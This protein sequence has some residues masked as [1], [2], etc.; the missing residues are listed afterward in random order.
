MENNAQ[1]AAKSVCVACGEE[2]TSD[3]SVCPKDGTPLTKLQTSGLI[4]SVLGDRYE[5][6]SLIGD[7][8]MG[9]VY[10]ARHKLLKRIVAVKMLHQNL[11]AGASALK[12]FQKEAELA[13]ALNHPNILT[14]HD[15]GVTDEGSPYLVMA[16]LEGKSLAEATAGGK[17]LELK[18]AIHIFKQVCQ[19][20]GHAHEHGVVHRD[21]KPSNIMLVKLDDD[22][23]FVK[24]VDF[25]IA[26]LLAPGES[27]DNLTRTGEVFGSPPYMSPEQCR[28]K[29]VDARS[30]IYAMGCLMYRTVSG[31]QPISGNDLIEYLYKHVNETP[32][33]FSIVAPEL[34]IPA[35]LEEVIFKA[36][37]KA[38]EDRFQSMAELKAALEPI[39]N[40]IPGA[41]LTSTEI[42][43]LVL[44]GELEKANAEQH[45]A[46]ETE[47][48]K[49][50]PESSAAEKADK[51]ETVS[52]AIADT[53]DGAIS[54]SIKLSASVPHEK[55]R[56]ADSATVGDVANNETQ[57]KN[58]PLSIT[59]AASPL[60]QGLKQKL[61]IGA[62]AVILLGTIASALIFKGD[63]KPVEKE[64]SKLQAEAR[65]DYNKGNYA[66]A[67][68]KIREAIKLADKA[69]SPKNAINHHL[70]GLMQYAMGSFDDAQ[71]N[72]EQA[73]S[74]YQ[75]DYP[76]DIAAISDCEAYLGRAATALGQYKEAEDMLKKSLS[77]RQKKFGN[78]DLNVAD[79]LTGL[80]YLN[81]RRKMIAPAEEELT[82]ALA[83]TEKHTGAASQQTAAALNNLGQAQQLAGKYKE[84]ENLYRKGL[85]I[86]S[87][88]LEK[89]SPYLADSYNC[90]G[91]VC[92]ATGR[93]KEARD[94][95]RKAL[96]IQE[97]TLSPSDPR[98]TQTQKQYADVVLK[99]GR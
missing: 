98:L 52:S 50:V 31:V 80:A 54:S 68:L 88:T 63:E 25:G 2:F 37:A 60:P 44:E 79:S 69:Q 61:Q 1:A 74:S 76:D 36:M 90:L 58:I 15:F 94:Y 13:S 83:I 7:G 42:P 96:N 17:S 49:T 24:I 32:A 75:K 67:K 56:T 53:T 12:R 64:I 81:M 84:A 16:F 73:L 20:L 26:K 48:Q 35:Q 43:R 91:A 62:V 85:A 45:A 78:E 87:S 55:E 72:L 66:P 19:G 22:P 4:G 10:R 29:E 97:K 46:N 40:T 86:R 89:T 33:S 3:L 41:A 34:N 28:A 92:A 77:D 93:F 59:A 14:V 70:L 8:A 30:D 82:K 99:M 5:I 38:P 23:D 18:R 11:I 39:Y 21:L 95:Y 65:Q 27:T 71:A 6:L 9:Q 57:R 47:S 51:A